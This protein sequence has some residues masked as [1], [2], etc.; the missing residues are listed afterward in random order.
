MAE[1]E[2]KARAAR[3]KTA[4]LKAIRLAKEAQA[5]N[6]PGSPKLAERQPPRRRKQ[7][8]VRSRHDV[9]Q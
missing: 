3:E 7:H 5:C 1:Y 4:R 8:L 2:A 9:H 6:E